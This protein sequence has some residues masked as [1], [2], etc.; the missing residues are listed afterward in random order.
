MLGAAHHADGQADV[1]ADGPICA[2]P[3]TCERRPEAEHLGVAPGAVGGHGHGEAA[4]AD[5]AD[6]RVRAGQRAAAG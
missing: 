4:A 6:E 5:A 2:V 3:S 1:R